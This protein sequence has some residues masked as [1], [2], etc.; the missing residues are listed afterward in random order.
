MTLEAEN[1]PLDEK[2]KAL[3]ARR[4]PLRPSTLISVREHQEYR[5]AGLFFRAVDTIFLIAAT[6]YFFKHAAERSNLEATVLD[7]TPAIA[8]V[9]FTGFMLLTLGL[10]RFLLHWSLVR[11]LVSLAVLWYLQSSL[12]QPTCCRFF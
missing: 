1:R 8:S 6:I 3:L 12:G 2:N 7:L 11:P 4:G 5:L 9:F 10:Y